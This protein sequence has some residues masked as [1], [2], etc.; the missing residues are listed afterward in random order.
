[1]RLHSK[2]LKEAQF[3]E[4]IGLIRDKLYRLAYCYVKNEQEALDIVSEATYKG[5]LAYGRLQP[6]TYFD[7]WMSRIVINTAIDHLRRNKRMTYI[8]DQQGRELAAPAQGATLEEKMD[9]Y[10]ALDRLAPEEKTY[11]ILKFFVSLSFKEM[12]QVLSL[13]ENTVKTRFYRIIK[14]LKNDLL[15]GE[16]EHV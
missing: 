1:M 3:S 15:E 12:A 5:Y 8:E 16:V 2:K 7:T 13:S 11:I 9:L 14:K 4:K 6:M 10:D